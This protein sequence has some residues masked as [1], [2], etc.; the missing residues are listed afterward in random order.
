MP[1]A[2]FGLMTHSTARMGLDALLGMGVY[3][4][5]VLGALLLAFAFLMLVYAL[6]RAPLAAG[7]CA[8]QP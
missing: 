1:A 2:V 4:L 6:G 7:V 8:R 3:V 5:T